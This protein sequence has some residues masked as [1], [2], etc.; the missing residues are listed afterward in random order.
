MTVQPSS[1]ASAIQVIGRSAGKFAAK[2]IRAANRLEARVLQ[3]RS[4]VFVSVRVRKW[5]FAF[6]KLTIVVIASSFAISVA[7]LL[8]GL[9]VL[10]ALPISAG[11]AAPSLDDS[12]HPEHYH[13]YPEL[14]DEYG[15]LK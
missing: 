1:T 13:R 3:S 2:V 14:Y 15:S 11:R 10:A 4:L 9:F 6:L 7:I 12:D 5:I 8:L